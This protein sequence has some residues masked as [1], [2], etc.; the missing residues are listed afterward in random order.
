MA[1]TRR[2]SDDSLFHVI[3]D[4]HGVGDHDAVPCAVG[5]CQLEMNHLWG[6]KLC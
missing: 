1:R 3:I 6:W 2:Q 5:C 4:H